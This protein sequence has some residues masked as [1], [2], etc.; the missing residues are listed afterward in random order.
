MSIRTDFVSNS[1]SSSFICTEP[2]S[3]NIDI[4]GFYDYTSLRNIVR[5]WE[6]DTF[7][8]TRY[9][10]IRD[11]KYIPD[12]DYSKN[13]GHT[14]SYT[15]PESVKHL[16]DNYIDILN[17]LRI[18][19][20]EELVN[21]LDKLNLEIT[22]HIYNILKPEWDNISFI[23]IESSDEEERYMYREFS[24]LYDSKFYRTYNNH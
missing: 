13:F 15:L 7:D 14:Q 2:D 10:G 19:Y 3:K 12:S 11:I 4:Y 5:G 16:I 6:F 23:C 21:K 18:K 22:E 20:D 8:N 1:S 24:K 17:N 9:D